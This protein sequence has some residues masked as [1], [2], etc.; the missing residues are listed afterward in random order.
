ME[1][2]LSKLYEKMQQVTNKHIWIKEAPK[3]IPKVGDVES[4]L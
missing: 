3:A 1:K 2:E 4:K